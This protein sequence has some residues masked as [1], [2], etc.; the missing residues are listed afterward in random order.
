MILIFLK[1]FL[2][3]F[4]SFANT[5]IGMIVIGIALVI[6]SVFYAHNSGVNSGITYQK[7]VYQK[8]Y[9]AQLAKLKAEQLEKQDKANKDGELFLEKQKKLAVVYLKKISDLEKLIKNNPTSKTNKCIKDDKVFDDFLK[10]L[11]ES[12]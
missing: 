3:V 2:S 8:E 1:S 7:Q 4:I 5:K 6:A 9:D 12:K 11:G 10:I